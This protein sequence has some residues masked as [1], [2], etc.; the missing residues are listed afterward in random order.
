MQ[1]SPLFSIPDLT[2]L[3]HGENYKICWVSLVLFIFYFLRW[4][5]GFEITLVFPVEGCMLCHWSNSGDMIQSSAKIDE[6]WSS[7]FSLAFGVNKS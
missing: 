3:P 7:F 4:Q 5:P 1:F 2:M 6:W